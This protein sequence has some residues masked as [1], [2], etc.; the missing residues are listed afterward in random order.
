MK[1]KINWISVVW[2]VLKFILTLGISHLKKR[3]DRLSSTL[4][5][6]QLDRNQR[7]Q[8]IL[9]TVVETG[10]TFSDKLDDI[11]EK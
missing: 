8:D 1:K 11:V 7:A 10:D 4:T 5:Q 3:K 2:D 6:E 9:G